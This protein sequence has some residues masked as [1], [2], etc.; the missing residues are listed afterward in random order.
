ME[1]CRADTSEL[2]NFVLARLL[3]W[4]EDAKVVWELADWQKLRDLAY[5]NW[6][7]NDWTIRAE[8]KQKVALLI[9]EY[10]EQVQGQLRLF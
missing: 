5:A 10:R 4:D 8:F 9:N 1:K 2:R 7:H 3:G 6:H